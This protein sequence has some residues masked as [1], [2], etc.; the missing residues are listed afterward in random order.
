MRLRDFK[1]STDIFLPA[2]FILV[3]VWGIVG[4][5][6]QVA[7][8]A[9][10]LFIIQVLFVLRRVERAQPD[11]SWRGLVSDA[12]YRWI[13]RRTTILGVL[14][15][16]LIGSVTL[17]LLGLPFYVAGAA[18]GGLTAICLLVAV[19]VRSIRERIRK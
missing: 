11:G 9:G 8:L 2:A 14:L 6:P 12:W 3:S 19:W 17:L 18:G 1:W 5:S 16:T 4:G 15:G 7:F 13:D 10:A